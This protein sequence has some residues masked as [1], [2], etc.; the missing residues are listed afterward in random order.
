MNITKFARIGLLLCLALAGSAF[1][2]S[3][4]YFG[5]GVAVNPWYPP[6]PAFYAPY[7]GY[8]PTYVIQPA[9]VIVQPPP[10]YVEQPR[11]APIQ[12]WHYCRSA[13]AYYPYVKECREGWERVLPTPAQ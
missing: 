13:R 8:P 6:P 2:H 11:P 12:Y 5:V 1:G 10:V 4:V 3:R 7:Y 9:P